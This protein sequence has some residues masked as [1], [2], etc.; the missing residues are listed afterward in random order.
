VLAHDKIEKA[1]QQRVDAS[2][3]I[4]E[5]EALI[6]LSKT[7][8]EKAKLAFDSV[9]IREHESLIELAEKEIN[10]AKSLDIEA[11]NL[12]KKLTLEKAEVESKI[13]LFRLVNKFFQERVDAHL[14]LIDADVDIAV[15][16][17]EFKKIDDAF[18]NLDF[19]EVESKEGV[20]FKSIDYYDTIKLPSLVTAENTIKA[21]KEGKISIKDAFD[22]FMNL[23]NE[24]GYKKEISEF[25]LDK[26]L[27]NFAAMKDMY[28]FISYN[29]SLKYNNDIHN[30]VL[31]FIDSSEVLC[32]KT[33][34]SIQKFN[35]VLEAIK[36]KKDT[37]TKADVFA[38]HDMYG[39]AKQ[40][41]KISE[42]ACIERLQILKD[43]VSSEKEAHIALDNLLQATK[44][45]CETSAYLL[46]KI[47]KGDV[48]LKVKDQHINI[49][50]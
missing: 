5:E 23:G 27:T 2:K 37:Y 30:K 16:K 50:Q 17:A 47:D 49:Q 46:G 20:I 24:C 35:E 34:A 29:E 44:Y 12:I 15:M 31:K 45:L 9:T 13:L 40:Y 48:G 41:L 39:K 19:M 26:N 4:S 6:E 42:D 11:I 25:I 43:I 32:K 10:R 8:I 33:D 21:L 14:I 22:V 7:E 38:L 28:S 3:A 36:V 1:L 18:I